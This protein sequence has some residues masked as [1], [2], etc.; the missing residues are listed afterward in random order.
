MTIFRVGILA[1]I[2][3]I[4]GC[5]TKSD[6]QVVIDFWVMGREGEAVQQLIPEFESRN[7]GIKVQVQQIPW[8]AAHEKLLTAYA[9]DSMPDV[10]QL[11]NTWIPEFVALRAIT[12]LAPWINAS[13]SLNPVDFFPGILATNIIDGHLYGVP[14]YVDTRVVFYRKDMLE[15]VGYADMPHTWEDWLK[16]MR[17][18]KEHT[19]PD[20]YAIL[21]PT[22]EWVPLTVFAL[23]LNVPLLKDNNQYGNFTSPRFLKAFNFYLDLFKHEFAPPVGSTQMSNLYQEFANGYFS[24]YISGPWNIGEF[25]KRLPLELQ[26]QWM[27]A[28]LPAPSSDYPGTSIAGGASLVMYRGCKHKQES[29]KLIEFLSESKQQTKFHRLTG[30]LPTRK[31][32]WQNAALVN[33]RYAQ[34]F[35]MQL[36]KVKSTPKIPEWER[37]A[38]K[39]AQYAESVIREETTLE[40]ALTDL[41]RDV[42][43]ILEKRRWLLAKQQ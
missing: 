43:L 35:L 4:M 19:G 38:T 1:F 16:L 33:N 3:S 18:I 15:R 5:G 26:N 31:I 9:G 41:N 6:S 27:T 17:R 8:S 39:L 24:M 28:P 10:F 36:Q 13:D 7:P 42:N 20:K 25:Q 2:L 34:A 37:I 11:G 23:Q 14:W 30:D 40:A 22:N 32:V 21:L 12:N 29:W